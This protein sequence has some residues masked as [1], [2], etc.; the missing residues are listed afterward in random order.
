[1]ESVNN[2][3]N[4]L[5]QKRL[6][7][8]MTLKDVAKKVGVSEG[9]ISRWESGDIENMRRDKISKLADAL[10]ISPA[11]IMGWDKDKALPSNI[12]VPAAHGIPILGTICAG[13]GIYAEENFDG[14]FFVDHSIH[15]DCCLY[16]HGDSM[17]DAGIQ[18][19]DIAFLQKDV[20]IDDGDVCGVVLKDS[21]EAV[22]KKLYRADGK[23]I[24]Q[25]CNP[26]Y[27]PIIEDPEN[28]VIV[29]EMVGVYHKTK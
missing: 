7:K 8:N 13:N 12:S 19:G 16:V 3:R 26:E 25:S 18:D 28:V 27:K 24:L 23:L 2:I 29:G 4:V 21:D 11:V 10:N 15:A 1:M 5:K 22:L 6:E 14:F 17:M 20:D 9:T